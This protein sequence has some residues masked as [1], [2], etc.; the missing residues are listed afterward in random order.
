MGETVIDAAGRACWRDGRRPG[1]FPRARHGIQGRHGGRVGRRGGGR[2]D[3]LH[4]QPNTNPP[5]LNGDALEA[6]TAAP[7]A[8]PRELR[9]IQGA[10][11]DTWRMSAID[12]KATRAQGLHGRIDGN[13]LV[14]DPETLDAIF[15]DTPVRS[16][17]LRGHTDHRRQPRR[18]QG[19]PWRRH[20][21][22]MPPDIR[23]REACIKST[24]LALEL[25]GG[26]APVAR[27][28]YQHRRRA[29][30]V[31]AGPLIAPMAAAEDHCRNLRAF[32]A[33]RARGLRPEI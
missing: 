23:S 28:A 11:N 17:P 14:D 31:R 21:G 9:L 27:A 4:G 32:P 3:Q 18:V 7:G 19:D 12:P 33:L 30:A 13:M 24:R 2:P 10:S 20:P 15:R 6:S 26:T 1:A 16:S 5:T 22:R 25:A 29:G 8:L